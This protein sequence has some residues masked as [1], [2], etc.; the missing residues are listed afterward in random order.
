MSQRANASASRSGWRCLPS[1]LMNCAAKGEHFV[2]YLGAPDP[3]L[4]HMDL[5]ATTLPISQGIGELP[6]DFSRPVDVGF[7][8]DGHL[9]IAD[10]REHRRKY[11]IAVTQG[12]D[13]FSFRNCGPNKTL[14]SLVKRESSSA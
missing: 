13:F 2:I 8:R 6:T 12:G 14:S 7:K 1:A 5:H 10:G 9:G 4:Q 11:L 3:I